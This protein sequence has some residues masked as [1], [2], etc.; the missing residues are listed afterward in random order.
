[1]FLLYLKSQ[2][3]PIKFNENGLIAL[4]LLVAESNPTQKD[5]IIRLVVNLLVD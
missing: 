4:A 1:M 3:L 2:S 5:I